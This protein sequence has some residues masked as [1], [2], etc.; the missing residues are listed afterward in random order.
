MMANIVRTEYA[1]QA[2]DGVR[3]RVPGDEAGQ[4]EATAQVLLHTQ[5]Q[6]I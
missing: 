3:I 6:I 1:G 5:V 4:L 2:E